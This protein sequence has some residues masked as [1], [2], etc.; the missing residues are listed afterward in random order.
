MK[1]PTWWKSEPIPPL[2]IPAPAFT[3]VQR[4]VEDELAQMFKD[5]V[6]KRI[7]EIQERNKPRLDE[8]NRQLKVFAKKFIRGNWG[9]PNTRHPS[10]RDIAAD[11]KLMN[12]RAALQKEHQDLAR[13][14]YG[15][16]K[17][18]KMWTEVNGRLPKL[19]ES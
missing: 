11:K 3:K 1:D 18:K 14:F 9:R 15:L 16:L 7:E 19:K 13:K 8:I 17:S 6:P 2:K 4:Q 10:E 5:K 12:E